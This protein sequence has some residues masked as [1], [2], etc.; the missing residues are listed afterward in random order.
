[1]AERALRRRR[2]QGA[3]GVRRCDRAAQGPPPSLI[4]TS[5]GDHEIIRRATESARAFDLIVLGPGARRRCGAGQLP[6]EIIAESGRPV[7]IVPYAGTYPDVG[8]RR[9]S[10]GIA[11]RRGAAPPST[12]CRC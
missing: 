7:F 10:P 12:H 9:S 5:G 6:D 11:N 4:S 3:G 1:M 8:A 2:E